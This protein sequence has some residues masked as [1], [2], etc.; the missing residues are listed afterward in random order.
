[1]RYCPARQVLLLYVVEECVDFNRKNIIIA[2]QQAS[3]HFSAQHEAAL[4]AAES[5]LVQLVNLAP[6]ECVSIV[7]CTSTA[8]RGNLAN[9]AIYQDVQTDWLK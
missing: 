6:K 5:E 8:Q 7:N 4:T 9:A 3:K 1:M 2:L